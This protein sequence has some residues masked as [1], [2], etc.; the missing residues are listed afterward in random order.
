MVL[1]TTGMGDGFTV[2]LVAGPLVQPLIITIA[3][4]T[5]MMPIAMNFLFMD[6]PP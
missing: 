4:T 6:S 3:T 1:F 2:A 5:A